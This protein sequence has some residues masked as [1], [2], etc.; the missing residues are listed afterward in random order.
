MCTLYGS[1]EEECVNCMD[2][3]QKSLLLYDY[4]AEECVNYVAI[5]QKSVLIIWLYCKRV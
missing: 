3:L 5:L 2:I 1:I 4:I